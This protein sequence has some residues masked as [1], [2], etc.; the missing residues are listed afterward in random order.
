[1]NQHYIYQHRAVSPREKGVVFYVGKGTGRRAWRKDKR[2]Q[3]WK[4]TV[5][6]YG[7]TVDIL[8]DGL[9]EEEAYDL[10]TGFILLYGLNNLCNMTSKKCG[11]ASGTKLS[12]ETRAKM[13]AAKRAMTAETRAKMVAALRGRKLTPE[14]RAKMKRT[15]EQRAIMSKNSKARNLAKREAI[16]KEMRIIFGENVRRLRVCYGMDESTLAEKMGV[17][18]DF[19]ATVESGTERSGSKEFAAAEALNVSHWYLRERRSNVRQ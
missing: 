16:S 12:P 5:A 18:T 2:N 17:T 8:T 11:Q 15:P 7:Y 13:S 9:S 10:E 19:L 1:V 6:K 14:Q 3:H 4:S